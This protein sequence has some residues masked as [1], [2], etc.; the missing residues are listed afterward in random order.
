M[1]ENTQ[2]RYVIF[3]LKS[4]F[5]GINI[6]YVQTIEKMIEITRV[7]KANAYVKGVINL[8]GE[9]VPVIDLRK[10]FNI[11]SSSYDKDS[12]IIVNK[13]D[14]MLVGFVVDSATE[15]KEIYKED[16]D[17]SIVDEG[18]NDGFIKGIGKIEE[19]IIILIDI[20]KVLDN[21]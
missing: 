8:R 3:K 16:I 13:I 20:N 7:P 18:F 9:I 6:N 14:D 17:Y 10:R 15:V 5:Y 4:E 1:V 12:R 21:S 2:E 11:E 19:Q